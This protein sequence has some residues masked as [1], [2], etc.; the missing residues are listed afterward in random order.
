MRAVVG[1]TRRKR[2]D[3]RDIDGWSGIK[4]RKNYELMHRS[5]METSN[6]HSTANST[7]S[8]YRAWLVVWALLGCSHVVAPAF[9]AADDTDQEESYVETTDRAVPSKTTV[10]KEESEGES[11]PT[12]RVADS[13]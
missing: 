7:R 3:R 1:M 13:G 5:F 11:G 8:G 4:Y 2:S 10:N 9:A 6:T 12:F